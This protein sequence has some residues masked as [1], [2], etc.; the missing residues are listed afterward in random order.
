MSTISTTTE[1]W[2][3]GA[4]ELA[5]TIRTKRASAREV[6]E[7]HLRRIERV[8]PAINAVVIVLG[9]EAL[10]AA[11]AADRAIAHGRELQPFHGVPFTV[12]ANLDVTGTPTT[13]GLKALAG[14]Y[15]ERDAPG[16][17]RMRQAGAIPIGRTN[18]PTITVRWH[19]DSE[20]WGATVN[21][22]DR[23]RTPGPPV[24]VRCGLADVS[25]S[26]G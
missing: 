7:A 12:K 22:W 15:P 4:T 26:W 18:C 8:N 3:M 5:G 16:V 20:L 10:E 23:S 17:E 9:E 11:D 1:L 19:T 21:P 25:S 13:M 6:I 24:A 14:A 2:S